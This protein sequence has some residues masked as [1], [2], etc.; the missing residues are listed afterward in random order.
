MPLCYSPLTLRTPIQRHFQPPQLL[1][2]DTDPG[3]PRETRRIPS[4]RHRGR[5]LGTTQGR[6][7]NPSKKTNEV[8]GDRARPSV[9]NNDNSQTV[10]SKLRSEQLALDA[11]LVHLQ[12][13]VDKALDLKLSEA[14]STE[15]LARQ[16]ILQL[17]IIA[18]KDKLENYRDV[19]PRQIEKRAKET[20]QMKLDAERWTNNIELLEGWLD[21]VLQIDPCQLDRL[22][23]ECYGAEYI[24]GQGM[25]EL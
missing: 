11:T 9:K 17:D 1:R 13:A 24:E 4:D 15:L 5:Q 22:R 23:R 7:R 25:R 14:G 8:G 16:K 18:L 19:D 6:L 10:L 2:G 20:A 3:Q 21:R 12:S